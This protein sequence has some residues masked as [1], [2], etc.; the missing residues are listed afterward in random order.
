MIAGHFG[1]H[2]LPAVFELNVVTGKLA[3]RQHAREPIR[4]WITDKHGEVR[5]GWGFLG[6]TGSYYRD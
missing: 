6:T 3:I 1:T 5:I 2:G 4:H